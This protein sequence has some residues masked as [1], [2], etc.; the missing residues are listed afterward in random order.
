TGFSALQ[1]ISKD[2]KLQKTIIHN[3]VSQKLPSDYYITADSISKIISEGFHDTEVTTLTKNNVP[4]PSQEIIEN[5]IK[6]RPGRDQFGMPINQYSMNLNQIYFKTPEGDIDQIFNNLQNR[7]QLTNRFGIINKYKG[8]NKITIQN[9]IAAF[10]SPNSLEKYVIPIDDLITSEDYSQDELK[11]ILKLGRHGDDWVFGMIYRWTNTK[12]GDFGYT[13]EMRKVGRTEQIKGS[14]KYRPLSS[15][16]ARFKGYLDDAISPANA[17][18][19]KAGSIEGDMRT[20]YDL[21]GEGQKGINAIIDTFQIEIIE[22]MTIS[23]SYDLDTKTIEYLEDFWMD[24]SDSRRPGGYN[25]AKGKA[26]SHVREETSGHGVKRRAEAT[27]RLITQGF[28]K[29]EIGYYLKLSQTEMDN[30]IKRLHEGRDWKTIQNEMIGAKMFELIEQ[31]TILPAEL[32]PYFRGFTPI[33]VF[34]FLASYD[35]GRQH[36][37]SVITS[38]ITDHGYST[39]ES[40]LQGLGI[41][42]TKSMVTPQN[43]RGIVL[44]LG[45]LKAMHLDKFMKPL[46]TRMIKTSK[47]I[48]DLF[49]KI[50]WEIPHTKSN[51]LSQKYGGGLSQ[52]GW[53]VA[54]KRFKELFGELSFED[55]KLKYTSGYLGD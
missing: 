2:F 41:S 3:I 11:E 9:I 42:R 40:L 37:K 7:R 21:A 38:L 27:N 49:D 15:I 36:L 20:V 10:T 46:A 4:T 33:E 35:E 28:T 8:N 29:I 18:M 13:V 50:G 53:R 31:G 54:N 44:E 22:I 6:L 55:A 47:D 32:A 17:G 16:S 51:F 1:S 52:V 43:I 14:Y 24:I 30:F 26:G 5:M 39:Y 34:N 19:L 23:D 45:G 12:S 48:L 25:I